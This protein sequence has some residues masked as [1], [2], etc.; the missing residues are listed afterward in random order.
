[1]VCMF[2]MPLSVLCIYSRSHIFITLKQYGTIRIAKML[3][4]SYLFLA[5]TFSFMYRPYSS[6]VIF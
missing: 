2:Q 5:F 4:G 3:I 6:D 1:M